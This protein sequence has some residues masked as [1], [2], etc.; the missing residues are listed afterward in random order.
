MNS[1]G[2]PRRHEELGADEVDAGDHLRNAVLDL[3]ARVHLDEVEAL[4][5]V[6]EEL[7]RARPD[8][9]HFG[10]EPDGCRGHRVARRRVKPRGGR[11]LYELLPASLQR[12]LA[13]V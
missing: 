5:L 12:A 3:Q 6:D 8:V 9:P 11:F 13:L 1:S 4:V 7:D 10:R 2:S